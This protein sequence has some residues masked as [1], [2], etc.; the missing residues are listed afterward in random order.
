M[1]NYKECKIIQDLLP[2][3]IENLTNQDTN[4][5]VEKHLLECRECS[6]ILEHM[7]KEFEL[8]GIKKNKKEINYIKKYNRKMKILKAIICL[9]II[10]LL[11]I[12]IR[13][14]VIINSLSNKNEKYQ[15]SNNFYSKISMYE[16]DKL[17][18]IETYY[19][20]GKYLR[21]LTNFLEE[22][23]N[24]IIETYDGENTTIYIEN[25][26]GNIITIDSEI[27][28][29]IPIDIVNYLHK[30]N[31]GQFLTNSFMTTV[32]SV[33]CNGKDSYYF[34][35]LNTSFMLKSENRYTG[36]YID[37]QTGLPIRASGGTTKTNDKTVDMIIDYY[38]E[39]DI[40]T[41]EDLKI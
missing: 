16:I 6:N 14:A 13:K 40:V 25:N 32:K 23:S 33:K 34:M 1:K 21:I 2:N 39:F 22:D 5:Y 36:V 41:D 28:G 31:I 18:A 20:D 29:I 30:E 9:S 3:Y 26:I 37:K 11:S 10:I 17:S 19:K 35:N 8:N 4:I 38:Y 15:L 27:P 12:V 7:K 24:N